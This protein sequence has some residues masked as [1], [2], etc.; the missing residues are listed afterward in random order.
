MIADNKACAIDFSQE[1]YKSIPKAAKNLLM[2]MLEKDPKKRISSQ[3]TLN[4][5]FFSEFDIEC[6]FNEN[7]SSDNNTPL[8]QMTPQKNHDS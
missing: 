5:R 7:S 1:R 6:E 8:F 3:E 2:K 4:H